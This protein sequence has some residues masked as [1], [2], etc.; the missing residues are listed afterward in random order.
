MAPNLCPNCYNFN[1]MQNFVNQSVSK[2]AENN[3]EKSVGLISLGCSKNLVDSEVMLGLLQGAGYRITADADDADALI[4]NTCGFLGAAVEESLETLTEMTARKRDGKCKVVVATGCLPQR[5]AQLI[6]MRVPGVDAILGT[7]DFPQIVATLNEA[8]HPTPQLKTSCPEGTRSNLITLSVTPTPRHTFVYDHSTPRL[9]ATPPWTAYVKIA[10]GCDHTCS[11]CIIPSL[12]GPFRS[13]PIESIV[14]EATRLAE[15]GAREIVLVA[16]DSTRYGLDLYKKWALGPLL[17]ALSKIEKLDWIR[18]LYAYPSQVDDAFIE[19]LCT[20]PR[21]ARYLD[22]PLQ[23]ASRDVLARMRRGGHAESYARLLDRFRAL[24]PEITIRTSFIV[25]FPGE[26]EAQ[27]GELCDFVKS[28]QFDR[29]GVFRY[30]DEDTALSRGLNDKVAPET[31]E[32]RYHTLQTLQQ[33]ISLRKNRGFIGKTLDVLLESEENGAF[34]GRSQ[35]DAPGIDGN[36][37]VKLTPRG[38]RETKPGD[39]VPVKI[40][41]ASEYDLSG[42]LVG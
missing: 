13:R 7:T 28:Q 34:I 5:D 37:L 16:Q 15:S 21:V 29:I 20:A 22:I 11:F 31:I 41:G 8:F 10:E 2:T 42:K 26:S 12:R 35:R 36:I 33:K 14:Q 25:G 3:V 23:H 38:R 27:F 19:A 39:L 17:Q 40:S 6:K 18:V 4:V 1:A 32:E 24:C 9:R 30:S